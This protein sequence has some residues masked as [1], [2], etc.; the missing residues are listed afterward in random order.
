MALP[1]SYNLRNIIERKTTSI[2][3][4]LGIALTV[5]VLLSILALVDGLRTS[6][7]ATGHPLN[8]LVLRKGSNAELNS[9]FTPEQYQVIRAKPG[10]ATDAQGQP[11]ASLELITV[12][13]LENPELPQGI[14]ITL[15]GISPSGIAIRD[16]VKLSEGRW[17]QAGRREVVVGK[18]V[19][20]RYPMAR[21]G[22]KLSFGRGEWDV[23]GIVDAGRGAVNSELLCDLNQLAADQNRET[24][25]SSILLRAT[26]PASRQ[27]LIY[28]LSADRQLNADA[29]TERAYYEQQT[30]SAA[31]IEFLGYFVSLIMA[32]GSC[33]AA[34][35]TMYAAVARRSAEIGTLRVLGFSRRSILVSFFLESLLLSLIGGILGCLLVLPL[36]NITTG[37]GSFVSFSEITFQFRITAQTMLAGIAFAIVMGSV[38]G[39]FPASAAARKEI[40]TALRQA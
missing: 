27:A 29:L 24:A 20:E 10:I 12:I 6:L 13:V 23:V 17:F 7:A 3:T 39:L 32:I 21:I 33:F 1:L 19:A 28:D 22:R 5:A 26:D 30:S 18:G 38:G 14:N 16:G 40:L 4:A 8:I 34:M 2:M 15:R 37:I 36:N 35:N 11:L 9:V 25:L 31:P